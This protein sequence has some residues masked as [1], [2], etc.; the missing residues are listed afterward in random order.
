MKHTAVV[1]VFFASINLCVFFFND[2]V[3]LQLSYELMRIG[4]MPQFSS[5]FFFCRAQQKSRYYPREHDGSGYS[6]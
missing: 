5:V 4:H 6:F 3:F 2:L 1:S